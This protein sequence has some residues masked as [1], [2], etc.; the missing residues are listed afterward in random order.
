MEPPTNGPNLPDHLAIPVI[1][2]PPIDPEKVLVQTASGEVIEVN[3]QLHFYTRNSLLGH[4]LVSPG[5]SYLGGLPPLL[6]IA[7]DKEVLRDEII[8]RFVLAFIYLMIFT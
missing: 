5:M 2:E 8:Y 1:P 6:I 3:Q 4:P 7:G